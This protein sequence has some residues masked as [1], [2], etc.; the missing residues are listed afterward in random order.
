MDRYAIQEL[1]AWK[2]RAGRKPLIMQGAR[3]VGKT[4]LM[5]K[6]AEEAFEKSIYINFENETLLAHTFEKDFDIRRILLEI[7]LV[8]GIQPDSNTLLIFDEIQEAKRGV[9]SLKYFHENAPEIP[10][11]AA[12]SLLGIAS[13]QGDSFPVGKVEFMSLY[14]LS[15]FEFL[16]AIGKGQFVE[17]I[18]R[19]DWDLLSPFESN[20]Q[21]MLRQYYIVGGMPEVVKSFVKESNMQEVRRIQR[22]ILDAYERD[23][24]KH[25][26][27]AEVPR[28]R[29]VWHSIS[30]QLSKEN[31]KFIYGLLK[32]GARAKNF[33]LAIEWLKDAGLV[34]QV[35]RTKKGQLPLSAYEDFSAFKLFLLDIG[36]LSA[37]SDVQP[38][39]LLDGNA[40]FTDYKGALTEQYV[41]QQLQ[42]SPDNRIYY[43]SADN[44]QGEI[45]FLVQRGK[46]IFP[47]EVKAEENLQAKSLKYFIEKNPEL[48]GIRFSMSPHR[49][50]SWLTNYPLYA[51][52]RDLPL[53]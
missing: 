10:I 37:M 8:T 50:Q 16:E 2:N 35:K 47:I 30:G 29:M 34:Y 51:A 41:Y 49:E 11:I 19:G 45:D 25:A 46:Q 42:L 3:Q 53:T 36:L 44:S 4:W 7:Q 52:G 40:I 39:V 43:W 32:E 6:F 17:V 5:R 9:T 28:L 12:G 1:Y 27:A 13:H 38:S 20:L 14:P 21:M 24:S 31:K 18:R 48:H 26:P 23:F 15:F 33:E 22:N